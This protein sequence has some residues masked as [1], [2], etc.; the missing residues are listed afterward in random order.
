MAAIRHVD[1]VLSFDGDTPLSV[2]EAL[3]PDL[4]V[5]G[6]D[7]AIDEMAGGDVVTAAGGRVTRPAGPP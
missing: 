3:R 4:L 7:Y 1:C 2:I 6:A 5:K